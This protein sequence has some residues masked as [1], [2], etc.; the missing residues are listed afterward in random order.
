MTSLRRRRREGS[1]RDDRDKARARALPPTGADRAD[2]AEPGRV[3]PDDAPGG[4]AG[5]EVELVD[6]FKRLAAAT[7]LGWA[8]LVVAVTPLDETGQW[9]AMLLLNRGPVSMTTLEEGA[10]SR[11]AGQ[12]GLDAGR[13]SR[14][15]ARGNTS[16]EPA[17]RPGGSVAPGAGGSDEAGDAAPGVGAAPVVVAPGQ[18]ARD[19]GGGAERESGA[20]GHGAAREPVVPHEGSSGAAGAASSSRASLLKHH[21]ETRRPPVDPR[22]SPEGQ[23]LCRCL[24]RLEAIATEASRRLRAPPAGKDLEI[25]GNVLRA[26]ERAASRLT[27]ALGSRRTTAGASESDGSGAT[28]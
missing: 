1:D 10:G 4:G 28:S 3:R 23:R 25:L 9:A 21:P 24:Y 8:T 19:V 2:E 27:I 22:L 20:A 7:T 26:V 6:G 17:R 16:G 13:A 15:C 12:D 11:R 5:A 18:P 14:R